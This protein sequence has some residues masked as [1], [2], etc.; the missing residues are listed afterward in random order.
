MKAIFKRRGYTNMVQ[1]FT[2]CKFTVKFYCKR[3]TVSLLRCTFCFD[4]LSSSNIKDPYH[5]L[6][7]SSRFPLY[8]MTLIACCSYLERWWGTDNQFHVQQNFEQC[9][10]LSHGIFGIGGNQHYTCIHPM[11]SIL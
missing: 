8:S 11:V 7:T 3:E 5:H 4:P 6:E 10:V 9:Y 2:F 1:H